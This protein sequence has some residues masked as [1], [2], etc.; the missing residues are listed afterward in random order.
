V[1]GGIS[2]I[3]GECALQLIPAI[4]T[5]DGKTEKLPLNRHKTEVFIKYQQLNIYFGYQ[6]LQVLGQAILFSL[7][8]LICLNLRIGNV[9]PASPQSETTPPISRA[10]L[11]GRAMRLAIFSSTVQ[12]KIE[13]L[14]LG[15]LMVQTLKILE[16]LKL[17]LPVKMMSAD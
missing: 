14:Y 5:Y 6:R 15:E 8:I 12:A 3:F 11:M 9:L 7:M 2:P 10:H 17:M 1:P 4:L 13:S 16:L